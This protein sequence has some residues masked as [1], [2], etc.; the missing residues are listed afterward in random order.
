MQP[1]GG[2]NGG[3]EFSSGAP[4]VVSTLSDSGVGWHHYAITW[5]QVTGARR[6]YVDGNIVNS[7]TKSPATC[8]VDAA[9]EEGGGQGQKE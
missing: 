9:A 8:T 2:Y 5:D 6:H 4:A 7:D 1:F 3:Y